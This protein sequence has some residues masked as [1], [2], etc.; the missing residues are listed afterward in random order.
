MQY[1]SVGGGEYG[2]LGHGDKVN[3]VK[4]M[5]VQAL[6]DIFLQ[7]ITCGWSH[8]VAL[9]TKDKV[10]T[11]GNGDHGTLGGGPCCILQRAHRMFDQG[12]PFGD[13]TG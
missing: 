2:Q 5:L 1:H 13:D 8:S 9:T 6:D 10:Y 3:K 12:A 4:T 11:W 7:Q